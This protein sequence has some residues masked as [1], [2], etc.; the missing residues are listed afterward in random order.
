MVVGY[1]VQLM[2]SAYPSIPWAQGDFPVR[3]PARE[4]VHVGVEAYA[5]V[6]TVDEVERE[7]RLGVTKGVKASRRNWSVTKRRIW[8]RTGAMGGGL[9]YV[10][11][12]GGWCGFF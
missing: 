11:G 2:S 1:S 7:N 5:D 4:G 8:G 6:K 12:G 9:L 3:R 10:G